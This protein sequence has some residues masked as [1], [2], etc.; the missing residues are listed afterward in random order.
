MPFLAVF[1]FFIYIQYEAEEHVAGNCAVDNEKGLECFSFVVEKFYFD[2]NA[3]L[4]HQ[5]QPVFFPFFFS[6]FFLLYGP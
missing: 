4:F 6:F 2:N 5:L 1:F 3:H